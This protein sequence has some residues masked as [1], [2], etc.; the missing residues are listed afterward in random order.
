MI[1]EPETA[2]SA[3]L[4]SAINQRFAEPLGVFKHMGSVLE[5]G[6]GLWAVDR[7]IGVPSSIYVR[8]V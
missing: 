6:L 8:R 2:G 3:E 1:D 7:P 4:M 5:Y